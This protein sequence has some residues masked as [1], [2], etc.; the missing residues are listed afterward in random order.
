MEKISFKSSFFICYFIFLVIGGGALLYYPKTELFLFINQNHHYT[1]DY[2]F[3]YFTNVGDGI[4]YGVVILALLCYRY[5][6]A[7]IAFVSFLLTSSVAQLLKRLVFVDEY[8]PTRYLKELNIDYH[9]IEGVKLYSNNS[10]P[11]GHATTAFSIFCLLA[12]IFKQKSLGLLFFLFAFLASYSRVYI[13][14]HFFGDIY[15]GS[16]IG[17]FLT[18]VIYITLGRYFENMEKEWPEK[19]LIKR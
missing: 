15:F 6:Y 4:F 8:R 16:L 19:G 9:M 7:I 2:F 1:S 12:L 10:F 11:S 18:V 13:A 17:V 5:K 3:R 14:Q